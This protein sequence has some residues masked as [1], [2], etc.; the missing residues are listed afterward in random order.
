MEKW[1]GSRVSASV[2]PRELG[3]KGDTQDEF[4]SCCH[5]CRLECSW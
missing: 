4:R 1:P 3:W 5:S 2:T